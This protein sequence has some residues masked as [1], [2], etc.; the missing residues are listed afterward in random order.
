M[1]DTDGANHLA[2]SP[3]GEWIAFRQGGRV[4]KVPIDGGPA[5]V[6]CECRVPNLF[7]LPDNRLLSGGLDSGLVE[8]PVPW[9][10]SFPRDRPRA[11]RTSGH[12]RPTLLPDK[13]VLF[14]SSSGGDWPQ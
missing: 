3:D 11:S 9:T 5:V 8:L 6:V 10:P 13:S 2:F 12:H 4:K 14:T 7:W 1:A